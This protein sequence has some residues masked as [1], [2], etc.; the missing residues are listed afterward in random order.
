M[1]EEV[2]PLNP[3]E[4]QRLFE[5]LSMSEEDL[6]L[7]NYIRKD[8]KIIIRQQ[9]GKMETNKTQPTTDTDF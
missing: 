2:D 8:V 6:A 9:N 1:S 4:Q 7:L 5:K 3:D